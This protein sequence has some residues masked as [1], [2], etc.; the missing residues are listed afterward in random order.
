MY[1]AEN[2]RCCLFVY[3]ALWFQIKTLMRGEGG[4]KELGV[5]ERL[6]AGSLAG[7]TSQT[8]IYPMEV[9]QY[10]LSPTGGW[11]HMLVEK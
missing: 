10:T 7:A 3:I 11:V 4:N 8:I 2:F 5:I 6:C 1:L 9:S